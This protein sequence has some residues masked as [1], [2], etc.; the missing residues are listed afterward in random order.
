MGL[1]QNSIGRSEL[2]QVDI[3]FVSIGMNVNRFFGAEFILVAQILPEVCVIG[4]N[5]SKTE[6]WGDW[7]GALLG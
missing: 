2:S 4:P 6:T 3:L 1:T 5:Q 7:M